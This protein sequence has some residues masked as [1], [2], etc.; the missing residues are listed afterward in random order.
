[1]NTETEDLGES[2]FDDDD[3]VCYSDDSKDET[4]ITSQG[5]RTKFQL[6]KVFISESDDDENCEVQLTKPVQGV[7]T[8]T[9][10]VNFRQLSSAN[11]SQQNIQRQR[12]GF[13][14]QGECVDVEHFSSVLESRPTIQLQ[15]QAVTHAEEWDT[16]F[17]IRIPTPEGSTL[18]EE[19]DYDIV[20]AVLPHVD[21]IVSRIAT[22][23][24][25][26]LEKRSSKRAAMKA[27]IYANHMRA[28]VIR[29]SAT[30]K[31]NS[32]I[33]YEL[34]SELPAWFYDSYDN[35]NTTT[36]TDLQS[37]TSS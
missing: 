24:Q 13:T 17:P 19:F 32:A 31:R 26:A 21:N 29:S 6:E 34:T 25:R 15:R 1:M 2:E 11:A 4:K 8:P 23:R 22:N 37:S 14:G 16:H 35:S 27:Q 10:K 7:A 30:K 9:P 5:R 20:P 28:K 12:P 36:S 18:Q 33:C 3:D